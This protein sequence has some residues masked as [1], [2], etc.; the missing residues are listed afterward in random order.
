MAI[1]V[2]DASGGSMTERAAA[3]LFIIWRERKL[4][5]ERAKSRKVMMP[6]G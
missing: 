4:G 6:Q 3:G 2:T 5:L 1:I